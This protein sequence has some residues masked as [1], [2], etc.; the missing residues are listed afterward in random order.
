MYPVN[1]NS[2]RSPIPRDAVFFYVCILSPCGLTGLNNIILG[3][4]PLLC[5][6]VGTN[7][8]FYCSAEEFIDAGAN[9]ERFSLGSVY[10]ISSF[11]VEIICRMEEME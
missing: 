8:A 7:T 4:V 10:I 9:R 1:Y 6:R 11:R 3:K 5:Y 2:T